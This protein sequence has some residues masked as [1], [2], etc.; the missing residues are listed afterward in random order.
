MKI[1]LSTSH[2]SHPLSSSKKR[3]RTDNDDLISNDDTINSSTLEQQRVY[4]KVDPI[5]F[6]NLL[7]I[8]YQNQPLPEYFE[9]AWY[10]SILK[11]ES[12]TNH[13]PPPSHSSPQFTP[14][15]RQD[16]RNKSLDSMDTSI[17]RR[18]RLFQN[19]NEDGFSD[20]NC[21]L[22]SVTSTNLADLSKPC[23][24][25]AYKWQATPSGSPRNEN[26][27]EKSTKAVSPKFL[28]NLESDPF[29]SMSPVQSDC[30]SDQENIEPSD[31]K[32]LPRSSGCD[33]KLMESLEFEISPI[34]SS[35]KAISTVLQDA[36]TKVDLMPVTPAR[37]IFQIN[38]K[39]SITNLDFLEKFW[40]VK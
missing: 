8:R 28:E 20:V 9:T 18:R 23:L 5:E 37:S 6:F 32:N 16:D 22:G 38:K 33:N 11:S 39:L 10:D 24:A 1:F 29:S 31:G 2:H 12:H 26:S 34:L 15:F 30:D 17:S 27:T 7:K 3:S 21:S 14:K 35:K 4:P 40:V 13:K 25:D 36:N 19:E